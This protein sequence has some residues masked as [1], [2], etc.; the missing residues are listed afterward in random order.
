MTSKTPANRRAKAAM[1]KPIDTLSMNSLGQPQPSA[2]P[3]TAGAAGANSSKRVFDSIAVIRQHHERLA[4]AIEIF[5]GH[6][7][8][9]ELLS[10]LIF[11]GADVNDRN[12]AGF[13][14]EV[15]DALMTL[16][17]IHEQTKGS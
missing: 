17:S 16:A 3:W 12:R 7:E 11:D 6:A 13:K 8:C 5:W 4:R 14:T 15:L 10:K 9:D 2:H 1:H